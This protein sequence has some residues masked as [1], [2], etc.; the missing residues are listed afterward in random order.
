MFLMK[1]TFL[2]KAA[3]IFLLVPF[4]IAC[5]NMSSKVGGV[6]NLDTDVKLQFLVSSHINPDEEDRPSPIYLRLYQLKT[7][8]AFKKTGFIDLY[9]NDRE[10][11]GNELISKTELKPIAAGGSRDEQFV[12]NS[13]TQYVALF[14][15]FY[16]YKDAKYKIIV[17][18]TKNNILQ[19]T[20]TVRIENN[21]LQLVSNNR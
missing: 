14:A 2:C 10:K 5:S 13:E 11:L 7:D 15:E 20:F 19:N 21:Q 1:S 6:L 8:I 16:Q 4:L 18:I 3:V 9:E 17:P 12:L